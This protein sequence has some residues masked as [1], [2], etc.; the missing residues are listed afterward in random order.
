M[1]DHRGLKI[2]PSEDSFTFVDCS[3]RNLGGIIRYLEV[4]IGN[5]LV[6][7][8]FHALDIKL[9]WNSSLLLGRA[10]MATVGAVRNM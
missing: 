9:N 8:D 4:Q 1:A 6:P 7:V 2:E 3:R 5:V 10:F